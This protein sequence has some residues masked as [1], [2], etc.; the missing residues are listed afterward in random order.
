MTFSKR[1]LCA[2][3]FLFT[4]PA[5]SHPGRSAVCPRVT[6][7]NKGHRGEG[8]GPITSRPGVRAPSLRFPR[9]TLSTTAASPEPS[10]IYCSTGRVLPAARVAQVRRK[11]RWCPNLNGDVGSGF[12]GLWQLRA[13]LGCSL[14][15]GLNRGGIHQGPIDYWVWAPSRAGSSPRGAMQGLATVPVDR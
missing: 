8:S 13:Q 4:T 1:L 14:N 15:R 12:P 9:S 3:H 5:L 11:C 7:G 2:R 6:G 10:F